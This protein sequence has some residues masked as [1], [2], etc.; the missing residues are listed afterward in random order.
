MKPAGGESLFHFM[1]LGPML[2]AGVRKLC[3][4]LTAAL[5][6]VCEEYM[7]HRSYSSYN[8]VL[9]GGRVE[10]AKIIDSGIARS[11]RLSDST[12]IGVRFDGKYSFVKQGQRALWYLQPRRGSGCRAARPGARH[13]WLVMGGT[14]EAAQLARPARRR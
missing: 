4:R 8:I 2:S 6:A 9:L 1:R 14:R 5:T 7:L 12:L 11:A 10:R 3:L 13:K